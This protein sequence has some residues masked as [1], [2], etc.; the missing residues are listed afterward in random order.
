MYTHSKSC[1]VDR[2]KKTS[3]IGNSSSTTL[4]SVSSST[5]PF[6]GGGD[7]YLHRMYN[8]LSPS[9]RMASVF[10]RNK[11][12]K[13]NGCFFGKNKKAEHIIVKVENAQGKWPL[14]FERSSFLLNSSSSFLVDYQ[15]LKYQKKEKRVA[16]IPEEC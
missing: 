1:T 15:F 7:I 10:I 6:K 5:Q 12:I 8:V 11:Q 3:E 9:A 16:D 4:P 2:N 14:S 13:Q